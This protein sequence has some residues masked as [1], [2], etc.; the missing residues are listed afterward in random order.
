M[1]KLGLIVLLFLFGCSA[2][3]PTPPATEP[4]QPAL[5]SPEVTPSLAIAGTSL[6]PTSSLPPGP[7]TMVALGDSLTQGDGDESGLGYPGR[8]L[9]LVNAV[10]PDSTMTNLGQS[11][12]N[13]DALINGDQ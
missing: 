1:K 10:R 5:E 3:L 13:S 6:D 7:L 9:T 12:W 11:G 8:L 4:A 2:A